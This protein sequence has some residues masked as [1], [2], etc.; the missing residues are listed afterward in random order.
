VLPL[1]PVVLVAYLLLTGAAVLFLTRFWPADLALA[2]VGGLNAL[3]GAFGL[4]HVRSV[5]QR[6]TEPGA[7]AKEELVGVHP[8]HAEPI[9]G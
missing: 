5:G 8:A 9:H 3:I 1:L 7:A 6:G 4:V 2:V